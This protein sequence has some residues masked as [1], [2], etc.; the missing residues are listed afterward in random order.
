MIVRFVTWNVAEGA[1]NRELGGILKTDTPNDTVKGHVERDETNRCSS[2]RVLS[3]R[4]QNQ[5]TDFALFIST[6]VSMLANHTGEHLVRARVYTS[7]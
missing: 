4:E 5:P 2:N 3:S 7:H 1:D 6:A